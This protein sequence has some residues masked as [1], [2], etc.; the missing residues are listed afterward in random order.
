MGNQNIVELAV[1]V[2][3]NGTREEQEKFVEYVC[4]AIGWLSLQNS[5]DCKIFEEAYKSYL[6]AKKE[7][8]SSELS[9]QYLAEKSGK[10]KPTIYNLARKLGRLPTLEEL[11]NQ[12]QGRPRKYF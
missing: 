5:A 1:H 7:V 8:Q 6:S 9:V 4:G 11:N 10:S 3:Q 12:K 2:A